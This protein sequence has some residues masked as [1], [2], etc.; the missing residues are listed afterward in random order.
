MPDRKGRAEV[1]LF[2]FFEELYV[3]MH[4]CYNNKNGFEMENK[5]R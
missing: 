1:L 2:L 5:I 4:Q 3:L